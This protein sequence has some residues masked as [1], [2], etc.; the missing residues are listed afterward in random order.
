LYSWSLREVE[1][2]RGF[3]VLGPERVGQ[4]TAQIGEETRD[5]AGGL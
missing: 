3:R 1:G 5:L 4:E 2:M